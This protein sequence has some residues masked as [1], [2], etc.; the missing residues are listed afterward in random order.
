MT[1]E[2]SHIR[3][4]KAVQIYKLHMAF[5]FMQSVYHLSYHTVLRAIVYSFN[6]F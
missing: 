5:F 2:N 1:D 3:H 6:M 4:Y